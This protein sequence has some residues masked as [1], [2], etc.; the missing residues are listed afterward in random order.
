[1]VV[2]YSF[3]D[4]FLALGYVYFEAKYMIFRVLKFH[5]IR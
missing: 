4:N 1:M 5:K 3:T 2:N